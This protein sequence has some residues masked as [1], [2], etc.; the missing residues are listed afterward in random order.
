MYLY[1]PPVYLYKT[2]D[3]HSMQPSSKYIVEQWNIEDTVR[4]W[5]LSAV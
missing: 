3:K 5:R 1:T 4:H 2:E